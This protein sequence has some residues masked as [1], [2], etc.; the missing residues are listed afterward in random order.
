MIDCKNGILL[1]IGVLR[2]RAVVLIVEVGLFNRNSKGA[3]VSK[4]AFLLIPP[5]EGL[6]RLSVC[7]M[8]ENVGYVVCSRRWLIERDELL[9]L[10]CCLIRVGPD[11][12]VIRLEKRRYVDALGLFFVDS[13]IEAAS[14]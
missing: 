10:D 11:V 8:I 1:L 3:Q 9:E 13:F 7:L 14:L 12:W 2:V 6:T 4:E 5:N